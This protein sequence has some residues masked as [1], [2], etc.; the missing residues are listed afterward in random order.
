MPKLIIVNNSQRAGKIL[1]NSD[2]E[3]PLDELL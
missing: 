2:L 3:F 1:A